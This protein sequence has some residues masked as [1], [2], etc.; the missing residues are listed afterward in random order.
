L[1]VEGLSVERRGRVSLRPPWVGSGVCG[2][3]VGGLLAL[4]PWLPVAV[5]DAWCVWCG[6]EASWRGVFAW[7]WLGLGRGRRAARYW[8]RWHSR[9][10]RC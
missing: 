8:R 1:S 4:A 6:R 2:G 7:H 5:A 9:R 10:A 3:G